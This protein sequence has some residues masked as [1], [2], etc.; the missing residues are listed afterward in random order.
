[1]PPNEE[2]IQRIQARVGSVVRGKYRLD[3]LLGVGGMA[4]VF[5]ACHR[6][7]HRVALKILHPGLARHEDV[8]RRFLREGYVANQIDH[9][10]VVRVIDDDEDDVENTVFL[11]MDLLE[12][13]TIEQRRERFGGRLPLVETL[14]YCERVLDVL[15]AA[16]EKGIVH[17]DIKPDNLFLAAGGVLKVLDFGIAR[18]L[19]GTSATVSGEVLGT[20]EF[21]SPEQANGRVREIDARTDLWCVGAVFFTLLTGAEVHEATTRTEQLVYAATRPARPVESLAP[22]LE[23]GLAALVNRALAFESF[24]PCVRLRSSAPPQRQIPNPMVARTVDMPD[25]GPNATQPLQSPPAR[26]STGTVALDPRRGSDGRG[27]R[28]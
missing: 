13:E 11:A 1:M 17:R 21:M 16:H 9:P 28:Q 14:D 19:D 2:A 24:A 15:A 22:W 10:G 25:T 4:A 26:A 7:G 6:N 27:G 18:L 12:G 3:R 20:P 5:A 8:R 23:P